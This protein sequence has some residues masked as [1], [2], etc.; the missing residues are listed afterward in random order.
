MNIK[1]GRDGKDGKD[2][3]TYAPVVEKGKDGVTTIKFYPVDPKTGEPDKTKQPL[4]SEVTVKDGKDGR[5][6][7]SITKAEIDKNGH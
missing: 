3:I 6:G 7:K 1:N 5:D 4:K 2:G